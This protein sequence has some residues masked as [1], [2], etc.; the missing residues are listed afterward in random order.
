MF[1][2]FLCGFNSLFKWYKLTPMMSWTK[3]TYVRAIF[4][5]SFSPFYLEEMTNSW[6]GL[7]SRA[8][9]RLVMRVNNAHLHRNSNVK[10]NNVLTFAHKLALKLGP[11]YMKWGTPRSRGNMWR[12][13]P[14]NMSTWS[15][16]NERLCGQAGYLTL[17]GYLTYLGS[18]PPCK[19]S[20]RPKGQ[21][22]MLP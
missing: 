8:V 20:L 11:A 4:C 5:S 13:T 10:N 15:H 21:P 22:Y 18:P 16:L 2:S 19:Q 1:Y 12:V 9:S 7:V 14:P 3:R 17:A 6:R